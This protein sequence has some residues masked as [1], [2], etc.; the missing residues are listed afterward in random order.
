MRFCGGVLFLASLLSF[1]VQVFAAPSA[2]YGPSTKARARSRAHYTQISTWNS[3]V[4]V[5]G[6]ELSERWAQDILVNLEGLHELEVSRLNVFSYEGRISDRF[7]T[8]PFVASLQFV[9]KAS[10]SDLLTRGT[11][12]LQGQLSMSRDSG[13]IEIAELERLHNPSSPEQ[14]KRQG[15][16]IKRFDGAFFRRILKPVLQVTL[17]DDV[18][19]ANLASPLFRNQIP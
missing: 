13:E 1:S 10:G 11:L 15:G 3:I 6:G 16:A 18:E 17:T 9:E 7:F 12:E 2:G 5:K 19:L 4:I 8:I 14:K